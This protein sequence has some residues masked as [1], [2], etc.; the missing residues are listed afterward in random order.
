MFPGKGHGLQEMNWKATG[1][2]SGDI[3]CSGWGSIKIQMLLGKLE[4]FFPLAWEIAKFIYQPRM[5]HI[6]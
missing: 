3:A 4:I 1:W 5:T 2:K 6:F